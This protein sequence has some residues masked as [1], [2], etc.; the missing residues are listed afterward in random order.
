ML[1]LAQEKHLCGVYFVRF[2]ETFKSHSF[3][4]MLLF[5]F[6][7]FV[8]LKHRGSTPLEPRGL[9]LC[10]RGGKVCKTPLWWKSSEHDNGVRLSF[11]LYINLSLP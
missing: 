7:I 11:L 5:Y 2:K 6:I 10:S 4:E 1:P 9:I 3:A 8:L